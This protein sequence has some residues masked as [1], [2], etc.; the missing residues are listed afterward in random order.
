MRV[1]GLVARRTD[2]VTA[3]AAGRN[4]IFPLDL[5]QLLALPQLLELPHGARGLG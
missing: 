5:P 3:D 1:T 2:N 4:E